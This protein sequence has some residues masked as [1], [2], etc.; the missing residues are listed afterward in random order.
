MESNDSSSESNYQNTTIEDIRQQ[1]EEEE[2]EEYYHQQEAQ[3]IQRQLQQRQLQQ[4]QQQQQQQQT[5]NRFNQ[6][7]IGMSEVRDQGHESS[8]DQ[9]PSSSNSLPWMTR[10]SSSMFGPHARA[11]EDFTRRRREIR[12][13]S[14]LRSQDRISPEPERS[15]EAQSSMSTFERNARLY[16]EL[17][18]RQEARRPQDDQASVP[19]QLSPFLQSTSQTQSEEENQSTNTRPISPPIHLPPTPPRHFIP[20]PPPM[21]LSPTPPPIHLPP[22]PPTNRV[23]SNDRTS[24]NQR[25]LYLF[26]GHFLDPQNNLITLHLDQLDQL[27]R[28]SSISDSSSSDSNHQHTESSDPLIDSESDQNAALFITSLQNGHQS[29]IR[30]GRDISL[31]ENSD[32][33]TDPHPLVI[34]PAHHNSMNLAEALGLPTPYDDLPE[35]SGLDESRRF[36]GQ[37]SYLTGRN[38]EASQNRRTRDNSTVEQPSADGDVTMSLFQGFENPASNP[39]SE[40]ETLPTSSTDINSTLLN[41]NAQSRTLGD[42]NNQPNQITQLSNNRR[43]RLM[44]NNESSDW[45][46]ALVQQMHNDFDAGLDRTTAVNRLRQITMNHHASNNNTNPNPQNTSLSAEPVRRNLVGTLRNIRSQRQAGN[47]HHRGLTQGFSHSSSSSDPISRSSIQVYLVYCG[48]PQADPS[49]FTSQQTLPKGFQFANPT[50]SSSSHTQSSSRSSTKGCGKLITIRSINPTHAARKPIPNGMFKTPIANVLSSDSYPIPQSVG[51][52]DHE[53]RVEFENDEGNPCKDDQ[54]NQDRFV[55]YCTKE[56]I[57]CLS[58]GHIVGH[59]V[60]VHCFYCERWSSTQHRFFYHLKRITYIPRYEN[61]MIAN[62]IP[63]DRTFSYY[64]QQRQQGNQKRGQPL[65]AKQMVYEKDLRDGYIG[66]EEEWKDRNSE[67]ENENGIQEGNMLDELMGFSTCNT[68]NQRMRSSILDSSLDDLNGT[69]DHHDR[70]QLPGLLQRHTFSSRRAVNPTTS[71]STQTTQTIGNRPISNASGLNGQVRQIH[72]RRWSSLGQEVERNE[73]NRS[74]LNRSGAIRLSNYRLDPDPQSDT[75]TNR[76][77]ADAEEEDREEEVEE[78]RLPILNRGYLNETANTNSRRSISSR[79]SNSPIPNDV[80]NPRADS[81]DLDGIPIRDSRPRIS[82][83]VRS[84]EGNGRDVGLSFE[85]RV[86]GVD[87]LDAIRLNDLIDMGEIRDSSDQPEEEEDESRYVGNGNW[88]IGS[89]SGRRRRGVVDFEDEEEERE[90]ERRGRNRRRIEWF[91]GEGEGDGES[92]ERNLF[93]S[94]GE[95]CAR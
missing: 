82:R 62:Y 74:S 90:R 58:C 42:S 37:P 76:Q 77:Q 41:S 47:N 40:N 29:R 4:L 12:P 68:M 87:G 84:S 95:V 19:S 32:Y 25:G 55:C 1:Q 16:N 67:N 60:K 44:S 64:Q 5:F 79:V 39:S 86:N 43:R 59:W 94:L 46:H 6:R 22:T 26:N 33:S 75:N 72:H 53:S 15:Q 31:F 83:L 57:G 73:S 24:S 61:G 28:P 56:Y 17:L 63:T 54:A 9:T 10:T 51:I 14:Q 21:Q 85:D 45:R 7:T 34:P 23:N 89:G 81:L 18:Q 65:Q 91:E 70:P 8:E 3:I 27:S 2:Q 88:G 35:R 66:S 78:G 36:F 30:R 50:S 20:T 92:D 93:G 52:I 11:I 48:A 69:I 49:A 80:T 38:T 71:T 13:P